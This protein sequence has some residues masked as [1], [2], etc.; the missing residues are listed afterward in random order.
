MAVA[1]TGDL[2]GDGLSEVVAATSLADP[3]D[4][5]MAGGAYVAFGKRTNDSIALMDI[6]KGVNGFAIGGGMPGNQIGLAAEG[7]GDVNG[8]GVDDIL[9]GGPNGS[10][11]GREGAGICYLVFGKA[12]TAGVLLRD[13]EEGRGGF[14]MYG[15]AAHDAAGWSVATAGDLNGDGNSDLLIAA[16]RLGGSDGYVYVV[17]GRSSTTSFNLSEVGRNVEGFII[18]GFSSSPI[19][20]VAGPGDVNGDGIPDIW[21]GG[22]DPWL[23]YLVFGLATTELVNLTDV[24]AGKG[25]FIVSGRGGSNLSPFVGG[26]G[27]INSDGL[28]DLLL[29]D[30][31]HDREGKFRAGVTYVIFGKSSTE[32]TRLESV[33]AGEGGYA[34]LGPDA[35]REAGWNVRSAGDINRDSVPDV[36]LVAQNYSSA[37]GE[38]KP[39]MYVVF[40][41]A[42]G[43][44]ID[45]A[46]VNEGVGGFAIHD[47]VSEEDAGFSAGAPRD[48]NG[49]GMPDFVF[50]TSRLTFDGAAY[51]VLGGVPPSAPT[52]ERG[53]ANG[54]GTL[55]ITDSL[56]TLRSLFAD[57]P[58]PLCLDSADAD[59]DGDLS[60]TDPIV[61]LR[62]LFLGGP[63]PPSPG[64]SV[65]GRDPTRDLLDCDSPQEGC[66]R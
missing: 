52:F 64:P 17:F 13:I 41:K 18:R 39:T 42:T 11:D 22:R 5:F 3:W 51:V 61:S 10:P 21:I 48:I 33:A 15:V 20:R 63:A 7:V 9:L 59:D 50:G 36:L 40:G 38:Q 23:N 34:I 28:Q 54:D 47:D 26:A 55:D 2:N 66:L 1:T 4:R 65:C 44:P 14:S 60:I 53:D 43:E 16:P 8:D 19:W 57:G 30:I 56:Y 58:A 35:R 25:G 49:D 32:P 45:L 6:A 37:G 31:G 27:D 62:F 12:T 29:G 46:E 24:Y